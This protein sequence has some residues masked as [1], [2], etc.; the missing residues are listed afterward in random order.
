[1]LGMVSLFQNTSKFLI[2]AIKSQFWIF[3]I[4]LYL[5][6][7]PLLEAL[8]SVDL[9]ELQS[10]WFVDMSILTSAFLIFLFGVGSFSSTLLDFRFFVHFWFLCQM[11][12]ISKITMIEAIIAELESRNREKQ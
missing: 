4:W 6:M 7:T 2:S 9:E 3:S 1:M 10:C 5:C 8:C 11:H 12:L